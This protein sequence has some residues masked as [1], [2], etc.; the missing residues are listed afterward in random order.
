[1]MWRRSLESEVG[2]HLGKMFDALSIVALKI[3]RDGGVG[4]PGGI[5]V[6]LQ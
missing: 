5:I 6:Y 4:Y 3:F 1:M 2:F